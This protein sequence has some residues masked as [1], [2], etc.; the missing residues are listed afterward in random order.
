MKNFTVIGIDDGRMPEFD[1]KTKD[2]I[3]R[4]KCFSGGARHYEIV[5]NYLPADSEWIMIKVPLN[6]VFEKYE[7]HSD[8]V[9]FASGDPLFF[10]FAT[11]IKERVPEASL[12]VIPHFNSLQTLAHKSVT[13]YHDMIPVSLVGRDWHE[14]DKRVIEGCCKIG[15]LTDKEHSPDKIASRMLSYGYH[16]YRAIIGVNLGNH[17]KEQIIKCSLKEMSEISFENPNCLILEKT[18]C[19][20]REFGIADSKFEL[21]DN[22]DKMITK[23]GIRLLSLSML[24][25]RNRVRFWDIGFCTGS[26]SIEAKLQFPHLKITAFEV[27][28]EGT[29]LME[30]NTRRFGTPGIEYHIGDFNNF[31]ITRLESPD[32]IFIGGHG[33]ELNTMVERCAQSLSDGGV[34]VF[35]SVSKAS[36]NEFIESCKSFGIEIVCQTKIKIDDNNAIGVIKGIKQQKSRPSYGKSR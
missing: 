6:S 16:N 13:P 26:V 33:G 18:S 31:D 15:V 4:S 10:G 21:L 35:N 7:L 36:K 29:A 1:A 5:K 20:C 12:T 19:R 8:I 34:I 2:L 28:E 17:Y 25:L 14:F 30:T 24:D 32:A 27:R 11:T 3:D 23:A 9:V 22:R